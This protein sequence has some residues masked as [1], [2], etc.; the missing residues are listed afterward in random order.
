MA[1]RIFSDLSAPDATLALLKNGTLGHELLLSQMPAASVLEKAPTDPRLYLADI[2][3]GQPDPESVARARNLRWIQ[4]SSSSITRYDSPEFRSLVSER[5]IAVCNSASV[6]SEAC[7]NHTLAF[8]LAQSRLLPESLVSREPGGSP[9]WNRLRGNSV[10]LRGQSVL[11]VGYGAIGARLFEL[12]RPFE[13]HVTGVRRKLRGNEPLPVLAVESIDEALENGP[14]HVVNILPDSP[15]TAH[16]FDSQRFSRMKHGTLFYNIGRGSTVDQQALLDA[17]RSGQLAAAWLDVTEPEPLLNGH[18]LLAQPNCFI[19]PHVA[20]GHRDESV[21][22][23][24]HFLGNFGRFSRGEA[25][26]DRVM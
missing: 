14:D 2:A 10:P 17:L 11:I 18:P 22:L 19:T 12:L 24:R 5:G 7:A 9:G 3:F 26:I 20:G 23:V 21:T 13:M 15:S 1:F 6:Y 8:M 4:I 16:F 25:L